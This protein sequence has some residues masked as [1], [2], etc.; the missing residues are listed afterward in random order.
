[1]TGV[2]LLEKTL[3]RYPNTIRTI[4]TAYTDE[5]LL[6]DAINRIHVHR[7][8]RKPWKPEEMMATVREVIENYRFH[9]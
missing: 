2:E 1:M 6:M 4:L 7:Y 8:I 9:A 3:E 5:Q